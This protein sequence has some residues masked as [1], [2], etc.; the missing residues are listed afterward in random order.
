MSIETIWVNSLQNDLPRLRLFAVR[1]HDR[2]T[3]GGSLTQAIRNR[4][5]IR[6]PQVERWALGSAPGEARERGYERRALLPPPAPP[7]QPTPLDQR[8]APPSPR[9]PGARVRAR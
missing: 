6:A 1:Y 5:L 7:L 3:S 2:I 8:S 9:R 4:E